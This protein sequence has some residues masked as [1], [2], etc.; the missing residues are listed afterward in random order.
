MKDASDNKTLELIPAVKK[1]GRPATG[2]AMTA[3]ERM[4][5]MRRRIA[6]IPYSQMSLTCIYEWLAYAVRNGYPASVDLIY[7][8][9]RSRAVS[10]RDKRL[11][12]S[13]QVEP[14]QVEPVQVEP[15]QVEP[16]NLFLYVATLFD[17]EN[18][19]YFDV[20]TAAANHNQA[21]LFAKRDYGSKTVKVFRVVKFQL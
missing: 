4:R 5:K 14:A 3:A 15:A 12:E 17:R 18:Q 9:L 2:N 1:R 16:A 8:E 10:V 13:A 6:D 19:S 21:R 20:H 11:S 7:E